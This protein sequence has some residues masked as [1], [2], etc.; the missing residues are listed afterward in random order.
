MIRLLPPGLLL[1]VLAGCA[2]TPATK[3]PMQFEDLEIAARG[4]GE[5]PRGT[6]EFHILAG[7]MAASREQPAV[8]AEHFARALDRYPDPQLAARA[9]GLALA[10]QNPALALQMARR[11]VALAPDEARAREVLLRL[12]LRENRIDEACDTASSLVEDHAGGLDDG[13]RSVA[14]TMGQELEHGEAALAVM[15]CLRDGYPGQVGAHVG[16]ALLALR[17]EDYAR[18]RQSAQRALELDPAA[19]DAG[20]LL[21]SALLKSGQAEAAEQQA[22]RLI[23][24]SRDADEMRLRYS[25]LLIEAG[26]K[27]R[28]RAELERALDTNPKFAEARYILALL[29]LESGDAD[30]AAPHFQALL[31]AGERRSESAY[32]LGRIHEQRGDLESALAMYERVSNGNQALDAAS[33]RAAILGRLGRVLEAHALYT[34]L[35]QQFP[36]L[37][38]EFVLA[39][40]AMLTEAGHAERALALLEEALQQQPD[41]PDLLYGRS[42]VYERLGRIDAAERDLRAM[43]Q[44]NPDDARALNALGYM[45]SVHTTRFTEALALIEKAYRLQPDDAAVIDSLGW[46]RFRMGDTETALA[47]LQRAWQAMPDPEIAAHLG[48]VLWSLGR[49]EDARRVWQQALERAPAHPV[50]RGTIERLTTQ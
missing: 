32:Y 6:A 21:V 44:A 5:D 30:A 26:D 36:Q 22:R 43:I 23:E 37:T 35:R 20:L 46:V 8:A 49:R 2:S 39:E 18:A 7:E 17:F 12:Y 48:E 11:W 34:Q 28:A 47:L 27:D 19:E 41:D 33:R 25:R 10:G 40:S 13:L 4:T 1:A 3:P 24:R 31:A 16:D 9:T 29:L 45:L 50:L 42:L 38:D 14:H 15:A